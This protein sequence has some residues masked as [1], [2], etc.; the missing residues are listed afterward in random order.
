MASSPSKSKGKKQLIAREYLRV[1]KSDGDRGTESSRS[2]DDQHADNKAAVKRQ[3]WKLH[4]APVIEPD[5]SA[6]RF[7]TTERAKFEGM[8]ADME[9]GRFGADVLVLWENSRGS[10][11]PGEWIDLLDICG[12]QGIR[13]W[14]TS[15]N[16]LYD[17]LV[18]YDRKTLL[19][20]AVD[21]EYESGLTSERLKRTMKRNAKKGRVH[22]KNLYGYR[23]LR[24][25]DQKK[26]K[27][28]IKQIIPDPEQAPVVREAVRML[29]AG[30]TYYAVA[31]HFNEQGY[32]TRR[33]AHKEH[34]QHRGWTSVSIKQMVEMPAY[35][36]L[37]QHTTEVVQKGKREKRTVFY[38]VKQWPPLISAE[39]WEQLEARFKRDKQRW[40]RERNDEIKHM[41]T[42]VARCGVCGSIVRVGKQNAGRR[43]TVLDAK[44]KP[45]LYPK[46][47]R[48]AGKPQKRA[49]AKPYHTY[50]CQGAPGRTGFHVAMRQEHLDEAITALVLQRLEMPDFLSRVGQKD[51]T[52]DAER[53]AILD[54]INGHEEWLEQVRERATQE[55]KLDLL[56]DQQARVEP[57]IRDARRRLEGLVK[58]DPAVVELVKAGDLRER[59]KGLTIGQ[60]R[61]IIS[62]VVTPVINIV[63]VKPKGEKWEGNNYRGAKGINF[64]RLE[65]VW[66]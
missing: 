6:S 55:R 22:G 45:V 33:R 54:E 50:I 10:R 16:R 52:V 2:T 46:G 49:T 24:E 18:S 13:I 3:G 7:S 38:K 5:V 56:F 14:V 35:R 32:P 62:A 40:P 17:P 48:Y 66:K 59:W 4:P 39:E 53:Q 36:G 51:D 65:L 19:N 28:V 23:R 27:E 21:S 61:D 25:Y 34:N 60:R 15:H 63:P 31:K 12:E 26:R 37:R 57:L 43:E 44:G 41:L 30:S 47:H 11:R 64:G 42:G 9:A 29:L 58:V 8:V 1:S 20:S